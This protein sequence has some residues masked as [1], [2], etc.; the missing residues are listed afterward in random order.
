MRWTFAP[1]IC[2]MY[3]PSIRSAMCA[4]GRYEMKTFS[5]SGAAVR[6]ELSASNST[7]WWVSTTPL[8]FPVVP[9]V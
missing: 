2:G 8:G 1:S 6:S 3:M 4:N 7:L 5:P 9:E